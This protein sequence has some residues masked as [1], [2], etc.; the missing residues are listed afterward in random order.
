MIV[1]KGKELFLQRKDRCLC[2]SKIKNILGLEMGERAQ[3]TQSIGNFYV[4][5]RIQLDWRIHSLL[6]ADRKYKI[7]NIH[8][9]SLVYFVKG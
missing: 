5:D 8:I 7:N 3:L 9:F 2:F 6:Q 1:N 4:D